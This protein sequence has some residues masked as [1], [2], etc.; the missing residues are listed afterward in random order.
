[1]N[2]NTCVSPLIVSSFDSSVGRAV[3]CSVTLQLSIGH[4]F[5]SGSKDFH[6]INSS[7]IFYKHL[8]PNC[9]FGQIA[10]DIVLSTRL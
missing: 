1:M 2:I 6:F 9:Y 8:F 3:D 5:E 4:W 10:K 7:T